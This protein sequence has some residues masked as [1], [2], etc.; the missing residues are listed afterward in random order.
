MNQLNPRPSSSATLNP[1]TQKKPMSHVHRSSSENPRSKTGDTKTPASDSS[2]EK[3]NKKKDKMG[4]GSASTNNYKMFKFFNRKFKISELSPPP[5]VKDIFSK[6][7]AGADVMSPDQFCTFLIEHQNEKVSLA[8]AKH[9]LHEFLLRRR[10]TMKPKKDEKDKKDC[11]DDKENKTAGEH[12]VTLEEFFNFLFEDEFNGPIKPEV[13]HDMTA[14]L[15]HYFIYT[16]HNSYLTGNQL[17][18]D[19]SDVPIIKALE[20]GVKV[21]ELDLWPTSSKDDVQVYHG[22]TLTAPVTLVKCLKSIKEHA[23]VKSPYPVVI[24]FE[25][26]LTTKLRVKV[27]EL[28]IQIFGD[29]LYYPKPEDPMT[30]FISPEAL[31]YRIVIS[32][33][34]PVVG[35]GN[36]NDSSEE[37]ETSDSDKETES[38]TAVDIKPIQSEAPEY[39]EL[40]TIHAGKPRGGL[41]EA[42][43]VG[44]K[45]RRLSLSEQKLENAAED[46]GA[47]IVRFTQRN[48][49]R[50]YPKGTRVT[51][52]NYKPHVGWMHG[53]QMVAFN[54]QGRD[55][56][57]ELMHGMFSANGGCGYLKKPGLLIHKGPNNEVFDPKRTLRVTKTLKV[58]VYMGNGWHLDFSRTHFDT[59]SP[60]DFYTKVYIVGVPADCAKHKTE[61]IDDEWIPV[62]DEEF[63]FGMTVPELA[64]LRIE[65]REYDR[66]DKDDFGGQ[67][68]L[69]V[70]ELKAGIRSVPL[71]DHKGQKY[72]SVRLL[73][74]FQFESNLAPA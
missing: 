6:F 26:H 39:A 5:D 15:S 20:R 34:P 31:K 29:I 22:R 41:K 32:T 35:E 61:I 25:D 14:P 70:S 74:R 12:G 50:I 9:I 43:E 56:L 67:T 17:S 7:A 11:K 60:P 57:L 49:L 36:D 52:S 59:F 65:V 63:T 45:V 18:S 37:S 38:K 3:H 54:M 27:A 16:G 4:D 58:K 51:S 30:E 28:V 33:K 10:H 23:F 42:L 8:D 24:T 46:H 2:S 66:S 1:Q 19:C 55:K 48:I 21:I 68:C 62:W 72:T 64:V 44:E 73:M 47:D 69:P 40:I 13:H 53:A 71:Y